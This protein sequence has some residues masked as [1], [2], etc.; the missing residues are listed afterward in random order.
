MYWRRIRESNP[1]NPH[2]QCGDLPESRIRHYVFG[3]G[4]RDRTCDSLLAKQGLFQLS[5]TPKKIWSRTW[6][7]NPQTMLMASPIHILIDSCRAIRP[8]P[9][10]KLGGDRG[11]RI[12]LDILLARQDRSPLLPPNYKTQILV[13]GLRIELSSQP[14]QGRAELPN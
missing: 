2:R 8:Y 5:Y 6:D 12:L 1:S 11:N 10:L 3:G 9:T 14:L 4:D 7:S 13:R